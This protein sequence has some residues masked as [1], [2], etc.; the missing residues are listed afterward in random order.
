MSVSLTL[1]LHPSINTKFPISKTINA[2]ETDSLFACFYVP[3]I[4]TSVSKVTGSV[5][6]SG[7]SG[8]RYM[9]SG[10]FTSNKGPSSPGYSTSVSSTS[11]S[12][13]ASLFN[14]NRQL[15]WV[16]VAIVNTNGTRRKT[17][18]ISSAS[19]T[20]TG[21]VQDLS[22]VAAGDPITVSQ[23]VDLKNY[24]D[25]F[26]TKLHLSSSY[27]II[28]PTTE[29]PI[30]SADWA[31]YCNRANALPHVSGLV[32]PAQGD[33]ALAEYYNSLVNRIALTG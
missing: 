1:R 23:M 10:S 11:L 28:A 24:I 4:L 19:I 14:V 8:T 29:A 15:F 32:A 2:G 16:R 33:T 18:K 21:E 6:I 26:L 31:N 17:C 20:V 5:S 12:G 9:W 27:T 7:G 30:Q 13:S 22:T 3:A 25:T